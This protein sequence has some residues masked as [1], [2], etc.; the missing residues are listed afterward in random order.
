MYILVILPTYDNFNMKITSAKCAIE[1][2]SND[3]QRGYPKHVEL[4]KR[5]N[6]DN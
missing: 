3:R 4:Y 5:I 2:S 1:N 6:L